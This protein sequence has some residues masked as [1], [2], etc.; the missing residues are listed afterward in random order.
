LFFKDSDVDEIKPFTSDLNKVKFN[1]GWKELNMFIRLFVYQMFISSFTRW[2]E[3]GVEKI[4]LSTYLK[5][6]EERKGN[7]FKSDDSRFL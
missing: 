4:T 5:Q 2:K 1:R 3:I 7:I 6:K